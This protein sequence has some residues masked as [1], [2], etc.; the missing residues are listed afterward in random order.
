MKN[1]SEC[2]LIYPGSQR[3]VLASDPFPSGE[4][5]HHCHPDHDHDC[6]DNHHH[7][8]HGQESWC[9]ARFEGRVYHYRIQHGQE[10]AHVRSHHYCHHH[11]N[12]NCP[13]ILWR[14]SRDFQP[15][16]SLFTTTAC[17]AMVWSPRWEKTMIKRSGSSTLS[18]SYKNTDHCSFYW[19][20]I[21]GQRFCQFFFIQIL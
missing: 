4:Y 21:D 15:W 8:H 16:R 19:I 14:L 9:N 11:Y 13:S 17:T 1:G 7:H 3:A 5:H 18:P 6:H 2:I 12:H 20:S 10:D